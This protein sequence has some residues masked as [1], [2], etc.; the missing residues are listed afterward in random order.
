MD[1]ITLRA[2]GRQLL[3]LAGVPEGLPVNSVTAA[4]RARLV[5][6]I[7]G[8]PLTVRRRRGFDE[9]I[10]TRGGVDV[11]GIHPSTLESKLCPGLYFAGEMMDVDAT[12][13]GFNLQIAFS[14]GAL[15]GQ[16]AGEEH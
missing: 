5:S 11:R 1:G 12:T 8:I 13:G 4:Q 15:A 9:A 16:S 3:V 14:T 10:I 7:K 6:L 2:L